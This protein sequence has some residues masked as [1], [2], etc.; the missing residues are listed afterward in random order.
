MAFGVSDMMNRLDLPLK[1]HLIYALNSNG[2]EVTIKNPIFFFHQK[3]SYQCQY[4]TSL[5]EREVAA[6]YS[7]HKILKVIT[8]F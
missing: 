8:L 1:L 4:V 5:I 3:Q 2:L 6:L 7:E